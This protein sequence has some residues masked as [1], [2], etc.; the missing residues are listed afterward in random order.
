M[1]KIITVSILLSGGLCLADTYTLDPSNDCPAKNA[2]QVCNAGE[3]LAKATATCSSAYISYDVG[4]GTAGDET[5]AEGTLSV[6]NCLST[7]YT[8]AK[9]TVKF[10]Y[11]CGS[12]WTSSGEISGGFKTVIE[13][14]VTTQYGAN[15]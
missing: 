6:P 3:D 8:P 4:S 13:G 5:D 9:S 7:S 15:S 2:S 11:K 10:K 12:S 1:I 14:K